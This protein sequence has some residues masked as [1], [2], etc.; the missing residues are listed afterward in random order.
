[1][2][3]NIFK[4]IVI[5]LGIVILG[6]GV[7]YGV[8]YWR[9]RTSP[10]YQATEY[11]KNL[12]KQYAEDPYGGSTPEET[13]A[14]FVEALKKGDTELAAKYFVLDKQEQWGEDLARL[15]DKNL[16][17]ETI[18]DLEKVKLTKK[19]G[20]EAFFTIINEGGL[21]TDVILYKNSVNN[22]WK[23]GEF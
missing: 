18:S 3:R 11:F 21:G 10:E 2:L 23:I 19:T 7:L 6:V 16:L 12:E 22:R 17:D 8:Q 20:E 1:M 5:L 15:K 9:N 13:L 14:L 4:F